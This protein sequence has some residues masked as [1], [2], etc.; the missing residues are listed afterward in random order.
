MAGRPESLTLR[1][2]WKDKST[3]VQR[4]FFLILVRAHTGIRSVKFQ[5]REREKKR[6]PPM[7]SGKAFCDLTGGQE[8]GGRGSQAR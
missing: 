1:F 5:V 3:Y 8:G 7:G 2:C 4:E 6:V